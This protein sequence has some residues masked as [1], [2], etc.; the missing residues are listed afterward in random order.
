MPCWLEVALK[1]SFADPAGNSVQ[2]RISS[3]LGIEGVRSVRVTEIYAI[4]A[5][6]TDAEMKKIGLELLADPITQNFSINK[7]TSSTFDWCI[8][9]SFRAGVKDDAG[10]AAKDAVGEL[11]GKKISG[12]ERCCTTQKPTIRQNGYA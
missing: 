9:V 8:Q 12:L 4:D 1:P 6:L 10:E 3:E 2:S 11:L 7:P 5:Q